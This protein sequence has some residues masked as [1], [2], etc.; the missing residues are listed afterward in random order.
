MKKRMWMK[1]TLRPEPGQETPPS[2]WPQTSITG[3]VEGKGD[4]VEVALLVDVFKVVEAP[5]FYE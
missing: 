1:L 3:T 4:E 5:L 2:A